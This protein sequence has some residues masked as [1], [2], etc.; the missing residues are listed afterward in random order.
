M[1]DPLYKIQLALRSPVLAPITSDSL[2]GQCFWAYRELWGDLALQAWLAEW[3]TSQA[4]SV[5]VP[6]FRMAFSNA[7]ISDLFPRP[8]GLMTPAREGTTKAERIRLAKL[9]KQVKRQRWI[10]KD[11]FLQLI[12]GE[13]PTLSTDLLPEWEIVESEHAT[14][15][16]QR[17]T[18]L[19]G[20]LYTVT[21]WMTDQPVTLYLRTN[22]FKKAMTILRVVITKGIGGGVS[23]GYGHVQLLNVKEKQIPELPDANAEVWLGEGMPGWLDGQG[24]YRLRVKYGYAQTGTHATR[25]V[26]YPM[27]LFEAGST[28][29]PMRPMDG[30]AGRIV[31][32]IS[33]QSAIVQGAVTVTIPARV[34]VRKGRKEIGDEN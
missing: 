9:G 7:M 29:H 14:M 21:G 5:H 4:T 13:T 27:M 25:A 11:A 8:M 17:G 24:A 6:S 31:E 2:L 3:K 28:L 15:D 18:T 33:D 12:R 23:R 22:D 32:G 19:Q 34:E 16:R 26:K 20:Q 1:S 10:T 30:Y